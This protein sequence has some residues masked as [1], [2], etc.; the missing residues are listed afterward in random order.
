[1]P[2]GDAEAPLRLMVY[3]RTCTGRGPLPGLSHA[4]W[5]GARLY[6]AVGRLDAHRGV[7]SWSEALSWL[8]EIQPERPIAEVQ[9]WG[10]GKWGLA[11]VDRE[12]LDTT[13]LKSR[14]A[15]RPLL[16][17]VR[18]RLIGSGALWW[19]RTCET[20]GARPGHAFARG[21]SDLMGCRAAGHTYI[22]GHWQ[23]G[24]H[25]IDPGQAPHWPDDEALLEGTPDAPSRARWSR[26]SAPNTITCFHGRIPAGF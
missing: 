5:T 8:A 23:S 20:F 9:Y 22:I 12:A 3:D 2:H 18:A 7:G 6:Q 14:S 19:F 10:H 16:D 4:W 11:R 26:L 25:T 13:A 17:R 15:L 21:F 1:M 24:L